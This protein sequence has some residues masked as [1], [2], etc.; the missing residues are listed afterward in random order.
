MSELRLLVEPANSI[1]GRPSDFI[2][3]A[4]EQHPPVDPLRQVRLADGGPEEQLPR[5]QVVDDV[6][7][8]QHHAGDAAVPARLG[9]ARGEEE[10]GAEI[11]RLG[12]RGRHPVPEGVAEV[13][14]G[15]AQDGAQPPLVAG[16]L[17]VE[18]AEP[19]EVLHLRG[20]PEVEPHPV[21]HRAAAQQEA[22]LLQLRHA[23]ALERA[24][25]VLQTGSSDLEGHVASRGPAG[26]AGGENMSARSRE[27]KPSKACHLLNVHESVDVYRD[28]DGIT[29]CTST[30]RSRSRPAPF[31]T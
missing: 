24:E 6:H 7:D 30:C 17:Q 27:V 28:G 29:M 13:V 11:L 1:T 16:V 26:V 18:E 25:D 15:L 23:Q 4:S 20:V 14:D 5:L 9:N 8:L 19:E 3:S 12:H 2:R 10:Q 21:D 22:E 31:R